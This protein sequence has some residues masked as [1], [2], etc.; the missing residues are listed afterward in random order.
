[1]DC[2]IGIQRLRTCSTSEAISC[3]ALDISSS[4]SLLGRSSMS[5]G[6]FSLNSASSAT[7]S[8]L[9]LVAARMSSGSSALHRACGPET[10]RHVRSARSL[11]QGGQ[12]LC[13]SAT[14]PRE[15]DL[16][17]PE[18][19]SACSP[20]CPPPPPVLQSGRPLP[21]SSARQA[22][23]QIAHGWFAEKQD[24][25]GREVVRS[26]F[27]VK[28]LKKSHHAAN[29]CVSS[30]SSFGAFLAAREHRLSSTTAPENSQRG[31]CRC[32]GTSFFCVFS[33]LEASALT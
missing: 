1:M 16:P 31:H 23:C 5:K 24:T 30:P 6:M 19:G 29:R 7:C 8:A 4:S 25:D 32:E 22:A 20:R 15:G 21:S 14:R 17:A 27:L 3:S 10:P 9:A 26:S 2:H 12:P 13:A 11:G 28:P 18:S 33:A